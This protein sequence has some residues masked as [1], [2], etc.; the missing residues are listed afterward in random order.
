MCSIH[1]KVLKISENNLQKDFE[2]AIMQLS[3]K[4][5]YN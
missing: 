1:F 4:D 2:Q 3:S 5:C